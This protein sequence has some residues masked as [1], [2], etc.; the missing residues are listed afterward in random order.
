MRRQAEAAGWPEEGEEQ[1]EGCGA[2]AR[3]WRGGGQRAECGRT[4]S[5]V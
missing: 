1:E 2:N 5:R 3:V 4:P